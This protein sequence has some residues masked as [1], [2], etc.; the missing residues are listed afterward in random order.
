MLCL[1]PEDDYDKL[2]SI[3]PDTPQYVS[4]NRQSGTPNSRRYLDIARRLTSRLT[5]AGDPSKRVLTPL[6]TVGGSVYLTE[7]QFGDSAPF[8]A[9]IDTGSS[10]TWAVQNDFQCV[11]SQ[12]KR[13]APQEACGFGPL[14]SETSSFQKVPSQ[15]FNITYV[16]GEFLNGT[17]GWEN[18][19]LAGITFNQTVAVVDYAAWFGDGTSSGLLGLAYPSITSAFPKDA[20]VSTGGDKS[21]TYSPVFTT[22]YTKYNVPPMFSL[23]LSRTSDNS[24]NPTGGGLL[25]FGGIPRVTKYQGPLTVAKIQM[26][27][28]HS[29]AMTASPEYTFYTIKIDGFSYQGSNANP[30]A[31]GRALNAAP[32][33]LA[34]ASW[35]TRKTTS[36]NSNSDTNDASLNVLVDSGTTLIYAPADVVADIAALFDPPAEAEAFSG[37]YKVPC[38]ATPPRFGVYISGRT[39]YVNPLDLIVQTAGADRC[40]IGVQTMSGMSVLGD[41]FLRNVLAIFDVGAGVMRFG[42]R[43]NM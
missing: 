12:S 4:L 6:D 7:I 9:V 11:T 31:S 17:I 26:L 10:D 40:S 22:L 37:V 41:V 1:L 43:E 42:A 23:A 29:N 5:Q 39:F 2:T 18:V 33:P 24:G 36:N 3:L 28:I 30:A 20:S 32:R 8:K 35:T 25:A 38:N 21:I 16:D 15:R 14:Y 27:A 13:P 34:K 19:S